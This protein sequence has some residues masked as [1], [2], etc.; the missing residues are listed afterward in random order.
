MCSLFWGMITMI[1]CF[2]QTL[3]RFLETSRGEAV[4]A[5]RLPGLPPQAPEVCPRDSSSLEMGWFEHRVFFP[6]NQ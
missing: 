6:L 2:A 1:V 4:S 3:F 5:R